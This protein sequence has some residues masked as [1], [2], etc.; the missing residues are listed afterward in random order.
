MG[1]ICPARG[2]LRQIAENS[3][4]SLMD[5]CRRYSQGVQISSSDRACPSLGNR[6]GRPRGAR[7]GRL[8]GG[9]DALHIA[10]IVGPLDSHCRHPPAQRERLDIATCCNALSTTST[11]HNA[12]AAHARTLDRAQ[13]SARLS[14]V[15]RRT[16]HSKDLSMKRSTSHRGPVRA[17]SWR[18]IGERSA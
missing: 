9:T 4:L 5:R 10:V 18:R 17:M 7:H 8:W 3:A 11:T 16:G 15:R 1:C 6:Q 2:A 14:G 12:Q 13:R